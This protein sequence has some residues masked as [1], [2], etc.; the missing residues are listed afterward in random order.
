MRKL[1]LEIDRISFIIKKLE[2]L[3]IN[4]MKKMNLKLNVK[5]SL[6]FILFLFQAFNLVA[7]ENVP[8]RRPVSPEQPMYL[9]HIDTWNYADPQK[10]IDLIPMDIRPFVVMNISLS[11]SHEVATSRFQVAEY[12]YEIAKSWLRT[13]AQNQMWAIVQHSSGGFAQF[14]DFDLSVYEEFYTEYPNLIGFN[15]AEQFW[16]YDDANDPLSPKW[17]DRMAHLANLLEL[18]NKYGA[19]LL[20]SWCGN[21]WSPSINPI[22]MLKRNPDFA[23]ACEKYSNNYILFEKYTQQSYQS[24]MESLCLGAYLSGYSGNYGIRYDSSG[25]SDIN[26]ENKNF[27]MA[28]AGAV[29]LEHMLL[30]GATII[31]G[32]ELIW[33]QCFRETSRMPTTD[34]YSMRNWE[35]FPQFINVTVDIFRNI[36]DGTFRIPTKQ[37]VIERTK[38]VIVNDVNTG[39][40]DDIYSSPESMFEGLYRMDGDGNLKDNKS[41]FK[42]TG[43]YPTIPTVFNLYDD[44]ANTFEFQVNKSDYNTRWPNIST[45]INEFN[46]LFPEEYTGDLYAGRHENS[47]VIYNPYKT[48]QIASAQIPFKYNT[49]D[50]AEFTFS[51]YTSSVMKETADQLFIY[52]NN[53]D[54]ELTPGLKTN[55]IKIYGSNSEPSFSITDRGDHEN[56]EVTTEWIDG[57]FKLTVNHNGPVELN[58][59]C[60]GSATERLSFISPSNIIEPAKAPVYSGPRQYEAECFDYK[61][62]SGITTSGFNGGVRNYT[63]QG[64]LRM[65]N[66]SNAA[67]RATV[68]ALRAGTYQLITRYS[69]TGADVNSFDLFVNGSKLATP[70]FARTE[71]LSSWEHDYQLI[72]L[73]A[74]KNI[75]E[76]IADRAASRNLYLDNIVITQGNSNNVYHFENDMA[77]EEAVDPP[78]ELI[79]LN[80]GTAGVVAFTDSDGLTSNFFTAYSGGDV[81]QSGVADLE[82]F[83]SY[84]NNYSVVWKEINNSPGSKKGV[85]LRAANDKPL[86]PYATGMK[87][88]YLFLVEK[89]DNNTVNLKIFIADENGITEKSSYTSDFEILPNEAY[90]YRAQAFNDMFLFEFSKD[91]I[92]WEGSSETVFFDDSYSLGSTQLLWGFESDVYDW[93]MDN[94]TFQ[95]ERVIASKL[96]IEGFNY[97][98]GMGPTN[99]EVVYLTGEDLSGDVVLVVSDKFEIALDL[100]DDFDSILNIEQTEGKVDKMPVY[101]RMKS[102]LPVDNFEGSLEIF[103]RNLLLREVKLIGEVTPQPSTIKYDFTDDE[104]TNSPSS[105]PAI[106]ISIAPGNAATAGVVSYTDMDGLTS[107]MFKPYSTGQ[108]NATGVMTLDLFPDDG[109]DYSVTWKQ[110]IGSTTTDYKVGVLLRG[111]SENYGT[112]ST[113]YVQGMMEGYLFIVYNTQG[114]SEF[115]IYKSTSAFNNLSMLINTGFGGLTPMVG[116]TMWYRASVSGR[117][118]VELKFE[119]SLDGINWSI[120]SSVVDSSQPSYA[121]GATQLVWGLAA[122]AVNFY[123]DDIVFYG[124]D[125][126]A[127]TLPEFIHL[128]NY[129]SEEF[130]YVKGEGPSEYQ[131]FVVS[132]NDLTDNMRIEA[133]QGFELALDPYS[134]FVPMIVLPEN[135]GKVSETT[136]YVR[137]K[138]GLNANNYIGEVLVSSTGVLSR[139]VELSGVVEAITGLQEIQ[140]PGAILVSTEYYSLTGQKVWDIMNKKGVFIVKEVYSD[141]SVLVRKIIK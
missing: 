132:A 141:G 24:D 133:S 87:Q 139:L 99:S 3:K 55:I 8:L 38:F 86:C 96:S 57:V 40:T 107:N 91:S 44:L 125:A 92:N 95:S 140:K 84:A 74:G 115:R 108:R 10:I 94:I 114:R 104:A 79:S 9:V 72:E 106:N 34:G 36:L 98:Q 112:A 121:A 65:G 64:Y 13:C 37:E 118:S 73:N 29:H 105:P 5:K 39:S 25:W 6:I 18:S 21:Q 68:Y 89:N 20:V 63:G 127:G 12:G 85:L 15:Y 19:Y 138:S 119:Y 53:F 48:G 123:L 27:T 120:G 4:F 71:S 7:Q 81:N 23:A 60:S 59:D 100:M 78:A 75:I 82:M 136:I 54:N 47:W 35:T 134:A 14:S 83:N 101:I 69:V 77:T 51:Q 135:E 45:K 61:N 42:K 22:G 43:R 111:D 56:S 109:T 30:S 2:M 32:P 67:V 62:I 117:T 16:G 124:T 126:N 41:F 122:N 103:C 93:A 130:Y 11:I 90:W 129:V 26:G 102:G 76:F 113:G 1:L 116:Q 58:I 80:S 17:S 28:T 66:N 49:S 110:H 88:G 50:F 97:S 128:S 46:D 70:L 33:T 52:L 137:M 31:D 131:T